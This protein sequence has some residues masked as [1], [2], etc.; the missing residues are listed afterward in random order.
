MLHNNK[1]W[2]Y[3]WTMHTHVIR[4]AA[5]SAMGRRP[6]KNPKSVHVAV[7]L[8]AEMAAAID[9]EIDRLSAQT[10]GIVYTRSM[11]I[12]ALISEHLLKSRKK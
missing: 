10:P 8:D 1:K 4:S 7:R 12:R 11:V 6:A 3:C 2:F 5:R 9:T